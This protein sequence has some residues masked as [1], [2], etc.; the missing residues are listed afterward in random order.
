M[1]RYYLSPCRV[2][3]TEF[4][5]LGYCDIHSTNLFTL[6]IFQSHFS[7]PVVF[8]CFLIL[9]LFPRHMAIYELDPDVVRW[10]LHLLDDCT[11]SHHYS[12]S[13]VTQ[14]DPDLSQVEYVT[15]GFC[16]HQY[17][18]SDEA[19]AQAYQEELW[20]LD[21]MVASGISNFENEGMQGSVYT[22]DWPQSSN[23]NDNLG[24]E[25]CQNSVG[26]SYNMKEVG[27]YGPTPSERKNDVHENDVCGSSSGSVEV[28]A[29]ATSDD[30]WDS[31]EISDESLD[32]EVGKRLNQMVPIPTR[33]I[34]CVLSRHNCGVTER[35]APLPPEALHV[36]KTNEKIPSDDE[37]ISDH[38]RLLDRLQLYDLIECK[39]QGDGNCQFRSLSDQLYRS[40]DHHK[41]VREQIIQQLKYY[42]D[43][44]AGYVPLAYSDYLRNMSK[45]GEWGDHV[46]LQAA[47]DWYGVKIFVI[48]SFKDT[49]YIEILPQIQ[50]SERVIFLSFW[51]EVHYNSIYPEGD[52]ELPSSHTKKKKKWWNFAG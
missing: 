22:Q 30:F 51:A 44:Y 10:G 52:S 20:Q 14:Y 18:D 25:S 3:V 47:A 38:Q 43:L 4:Y 26:E 24:N 15:E 8:L 49:C 50:K 42:P 1:P 7:F 48:T 34:N 46:T 11:L 5:L 13:I 19:V 33:V 16:Q 2:K 29:T 17:V 21:S 9:F 39:V 41:F 12:P 27:N 45:S 28:P 35:S 37:E 36:P 40:P 6:S 23:G 32:G 31:L